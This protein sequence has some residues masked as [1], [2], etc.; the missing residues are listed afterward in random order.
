M[1]VAK[2]NHFVSR[3]PTLASLPVLGCVGF[4]KVLLL[5]FVD[6]STDWNPFLSTL[7]IV[8]NLQFPTFDPITITSFLA[9]ELGRLTA[10]LLNVCVRFC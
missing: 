6:P 2:W 1:L 5:Q 8:M 4:N 7:G 9:P 3:H 10:A